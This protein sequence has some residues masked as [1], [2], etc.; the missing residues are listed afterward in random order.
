L[1]REKYGAT[2]V[3]GF[4]AEVGRWKVLK[5]FVLRF[6]IVVVFAG[7]SFG[8]TVQTALPADPG[9]YFEAAGSL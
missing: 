4:N 9:M 2:N 8:Q 3:E 5:N 1:S 7:A 6:G